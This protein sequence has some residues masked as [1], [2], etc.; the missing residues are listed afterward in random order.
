MMKRNKS[1][2]IVTQFLFIKSMKGFNQEAGCDAELWLCFTV[3]L[4]DNISC[5]SDLKV[6]LLTKVGL[7]SSLISGIDSIRFDLI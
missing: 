5:K 4:S 3:I 7:V 1:E 6:K 2:I